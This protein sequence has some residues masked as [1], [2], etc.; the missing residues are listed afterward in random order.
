MEN[1]R[2]QRYLARYAEQKARGESFFPHTIHKD[3]LFSLLVFLVLVALAVFVGAPLEERADPTNA[4]Y[5]PRPEWY[6]MFLFE[7]LKYFPGELEWVGVAVVPGV[8]ILFLFL[9]PVLD[10]HPLRHP[11]QRRLAVNLAALAVVA[12]AFLTLRAY[13]VTPTTAMSLISGGMKVDSAAPKVVAPKLTTG[14]EAGK[15]LFQSQNCSSCH[16]IVGTG[17]A[18]G[19]DLTHVGSRHDLAWLHEFIA[20]P[21]SKSPEAK[22][23]AFVPPITHQEVEWV[24]Q[25][26][27]T[28]R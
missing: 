23:P 17:G 14:Q 20:N 2:R 9:L 27:S 8:A 26:L 6:F 16:Q 4:A 5:L 28:L 25:Y 15:R 19:P 21:K 7:M 12:V 13:Q 24:A 10:V 3:A 1:E 22:M 11:R 18:V